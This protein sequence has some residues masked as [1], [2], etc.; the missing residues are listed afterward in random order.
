MSL[1]SYQV[2]ESVQESTV[3][4]CKPSSETIFSPSVEPVS[5][6]HS[7]SDIPSDGGIPPFLLD[8]FVD[9]EIHNQILF[10]LFV[11]KKCLGKPQPILKF[12]VFLLFLKRMLPH[13][14]KPPGS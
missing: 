6:A 1:L 10:L 2:L 3:V 13:S 8:S 7:E 5:G 11:L 9:Y 4:I 12:A 14:Q